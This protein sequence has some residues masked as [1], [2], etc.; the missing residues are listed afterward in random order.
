MVEWK[1]TTGVKWEDAEGRLRKVIEIFVKEQVSVK[2]FIGP[3]IT[4]EQKG[5]LERV[6]QAV[7]DFRLE[8]VIVVLPPIAFKFV[9]QKRSLN[10][11]GSKSPRSRPSPPNPR[12]H[13]YFFL[14]YWNFCTLTY[15]SPKTPFDYRAD[16][17]IPQ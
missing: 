7:L 14:S 6:R 9:S 4:K 3:E 11:K 10:K 16:R 2:E 1:D 15:T 13:G 12:N 5:F 8:E 17:T